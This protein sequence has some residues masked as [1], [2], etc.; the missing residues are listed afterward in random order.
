MPDLIAN[1]YEIVKTLGSG[2]FGRVYLCKDTHLGRDVAV[3]VLHPISDGDEKAQEGFRKEA[4]RTAKLQHSNIVSV[5]DFFFEDN[6]P[7]LVMEYVPKTLKE[8]L[9]A[10]KR[11]SPE[12]VTKIAIQLCNGLIHAHEEHTPP[13][14]HRDIN[15][16]NILLTLEGNSKLC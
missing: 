4:Q 14:V 6:T 7:Y 15:P 9:D 3:K 11:L 1:R 5:Y 10:N 13:V 8:H 2:G 16:R 12:E